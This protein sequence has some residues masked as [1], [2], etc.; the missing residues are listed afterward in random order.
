MD[1]GLV[2]ET[3][4]ILGS[5]V[6]SQASLVDHDYGSDGESSSVTSEPLSSKRLTRLQREGSVDPLEYEDGMVENIEMSDIS[7]NVSSH[8]DSDTSDDDVM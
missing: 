6:S 2:E 4:P 3:S 7:D 5:V 1:G 8:T